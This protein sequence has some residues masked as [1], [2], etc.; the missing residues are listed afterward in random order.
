M[1]INKYDKMDKDNRTTDKTTLVNS[2]GWRY[3]CSGYEMG[4]TSDDSLL[5]RISEWNG[6]LNMKKVGED[7]ILTIGNW[8]DGCDW[9]AVMSCE[10]QVD[11]SLSPVNT[12][13]KRYYCNRKGTH[14]DQWLQKLWCALD[15]YLKYCNIP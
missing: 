7:M 3:L 2:L 1:W 5:W 14:L 10:W 13:E 11:S 8:F 6:F 4:H 9:L 12:S 15:K